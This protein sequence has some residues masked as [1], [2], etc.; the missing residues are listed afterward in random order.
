MK[1]IILL[2]T[3]ISVVSC[4]KDDDPELTSIN[5]D[6]SGGLSCIL[7]GTIMNPSGGGIGGNRT[8][9]INYIPEEDI[10]LFA[11]GFTS[12]QFGFSSVSAVAFFESEGYQGIVNSGNFVGQTFS[13]TGTDTSDNYEDNGR[14]TKGNLNVEGRNYSTSSIRTGT[15]T[16]LHYDDEEFTVSGTFEFEA[17]NE[18]GDIIT[19]TDGRFDSSLGY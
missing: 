12:D 10:Y 13:L 15:M 8:C 9:R 18:F 5:G 3:L 11:V 6:G 4:F 2:L 1:K 14:V 17:E 19:I 16:I 7:N